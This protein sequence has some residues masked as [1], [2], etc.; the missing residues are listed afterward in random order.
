MS[1]DQEGPRNG[2]EEEAPASPT[3][4][5]RSAPEDQEPDPGAAPDVP[6]SSFSPRPWWLS[7]LQARKARI[8]TFV[9]ITI[10]IL[11]LLADAELISGRFFKDARRSRQRSR[12]RRN[13]RDPSRASNG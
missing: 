12:P 3:A 11:G 13:G 4:G 2:P 5:E 7:I 9:T 10:S 1:P 6:R 8:A